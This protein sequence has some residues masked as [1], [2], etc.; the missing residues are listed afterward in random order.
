M[1]FQLL[2]QFL[3]AL[4][5]YAF[6]ELQALKKD[7]ALPK[8]LDS[9][10]WS[11][12]LGGAAAVFLVAVS[13]QVLW[14]TRHL[15]GEGSFQGAMN[16]TLG[17]VADTFDAV[18]DSINAA[19]DSSLDAVA[20][21]FSGG[22]NSLE[23]EASP[24]DTEIRTVPARARTVVYESTIQVGAFR[25]QANAERV[26]QALEEKHDRVDMRQ[27]GNGLFLVSMGPYLDEGRADGIAKQIESEMRLS[28]LVLRSPQTANGQ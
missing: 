15:V 2:V 17:A 24:L 8:P 22:T 3:V 27:L 28:T 7:L 11:V 18:G 23:A 26:V 21:R 5:V 6:R 1:R 4:T 9:V 16:S 14:N 19:M 20:G 25:D 12:A 10:R 13:G